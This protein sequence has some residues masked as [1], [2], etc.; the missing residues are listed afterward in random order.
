MRF[1]EFP[2]GIDGQPMYFTKENVTEI[3]GDPEKRKVESFE[4]LTKS[5]T[6]KQVVFIHSF[7]F[8]CIYSVIG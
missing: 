4:N 7:R 8:I 3:G 2:R 5:L 1:K 6:A